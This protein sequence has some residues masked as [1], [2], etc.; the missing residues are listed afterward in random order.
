MTETAGGCKSRTGHVI[1]AVVDIVPID[2]FARSLRRMGRLVIVAPFAAI[3]AGDAD[4][5]IVAWVGCGTL[6]V[7]GLATGQ[8][9][10]GCGPMGTWRK[11]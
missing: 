11:E 5:Q 3:S 10:L 9:R 2:S 8:V 6:A 4:E 7:T 1:M